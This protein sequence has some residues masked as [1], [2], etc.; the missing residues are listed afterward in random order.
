MIVNENVKEIHKLSALNY[1]IHPQMR[2][3]E[4]EIVGSVDGNVVIKLDRLSESV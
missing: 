3:S 2:S 1:E 4:R